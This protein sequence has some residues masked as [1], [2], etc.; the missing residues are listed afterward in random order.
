M[1]HD[2][3]YIMVEIVVE[4]DVKTFDVL[5]R[6]HDLLQV[7]VLYEGVAVSG[8]PTPSIFPYSPAIHQK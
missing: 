8:H 7:M 5:E 2:I 4:L 3:P 6:G 1:V